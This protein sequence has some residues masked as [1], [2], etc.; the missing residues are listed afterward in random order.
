MSDINTPPS[1]LKDPVMIVGKWEERIPKPNAG[2]TTVDME[3]STD[4]DDKEAVAG[5]KFVPHKKATK[6]TV[7][8]A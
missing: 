8:S 2:T 3:K 1:E 6:K 7:K 4:P 5:M